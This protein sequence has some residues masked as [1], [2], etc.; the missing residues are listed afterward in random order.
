MNGTQTGGQ[1]KSLLAKIMNLKWQIL[2]L[3]LI[4]VAIFRTNGGLMALRGVGRILVPII[5][6]YFG[7]KFLQA[8]IKKKFGPVFQKVFEAQR[9]AAGGFGQPSG[10]GGA[11]TLTSCPRC[12]TYAMPG[13]TCKK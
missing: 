4:L 13:H 8:R 12:G 1:T 5:I 10:A 7:L 6:F 2:A 3:S 11:A 9:Q